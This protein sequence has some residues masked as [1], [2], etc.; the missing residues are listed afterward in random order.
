RGTPM[1]S[2]TH[3]FHHLGCGCGTSASRRGFLAGAAAFGAAAVLPGAG[4]AQDPGRLIIDTH[5][6]YF[7]PEYQ[8][9]FIDF[10][11]S[12]KMPRGVWNAEWTKEKEIE[13]MDKAGVRKGVLSLASNA[14]LWFGMKPDEAAR[15]V[16]ACHDF[17]ARMVSDYP[18]RFGL[19]A[20]LSMMDV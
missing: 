19:F 1:Q 12:H 9:A 3:S 4:N 7:P 11:D 13:A 18:G 20:P 14:G 16:R 15:L 8:K 6:H 10:E 17:G 2:K 5:L